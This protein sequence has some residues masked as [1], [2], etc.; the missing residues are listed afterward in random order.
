MSCRDVRV[1]VFECQQHTEGCEVLMS[2]LLLC[3]RAFLHKVFRL[4]WQ[5]SVS[6][7]LPVAFLQV[8]RSKHTQGH[9]SCAHSTCTSTKTAS[10]RPSKFIHSIIGKERVR[11]HVFVFSWRPNKKKAKGTCRLLF[12]HLRGKYHIPLLCC[13]CIHFLQVVST[14]NIFVS[15]FLSS[16]HIPPG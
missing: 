9:L 3:A 16:A 4:R 13:D 11:R 2:V 10:W 7:D 1:L 14:S 12:S 8:R 5:A 15:P 6:L